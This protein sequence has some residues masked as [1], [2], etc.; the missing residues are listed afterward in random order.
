MTIGA[1]LFSV[2]VLCDSGGLLDWL[3]S[4]LIFSVVESSFKVS[5]CFVGVFKG[6]STATVGA[7]IFVFSV[8]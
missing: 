4:I 6:F 8:V 7:T 1:L 3:V 5:G 2:F